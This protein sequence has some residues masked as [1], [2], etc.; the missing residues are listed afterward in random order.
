ML[1]MIV[2]VSRLRWFAGSSVSA[3][4]VKPT[5]SSCAWTAGTAVQIARAETMSVR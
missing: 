3:S 5:I 1:R 2:S 4:R